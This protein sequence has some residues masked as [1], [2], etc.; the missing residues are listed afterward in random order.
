MFTFIAS[1]HTLGFAV[2]PYRPTM[3]ASMLFHVEPK[4]V[5][6][7]INASHMDLQHEANRDLCSYS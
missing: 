4:G 6:H 3:E 2:G 7:A 1:S 5:S